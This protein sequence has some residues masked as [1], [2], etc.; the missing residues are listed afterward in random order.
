SEYSGSLSNVSLLLTEHILSLDAVS[1]HEKISERKVCVK[2]L[3]S[4]IWK[5]QG[6]SRSPSPTSKGC[7]SNI[8]G[9]SRDFVL[10]ENILMTVF[11]CLWADF[12]LISHSGEIVTN[13]MTPLVFHQATSTFAE[14]LNSQT[15]DAKPL[16]IKLSPK[17]MARKENN[18]GERLLHNASIRGNKS[19][20]CFL[21]SGNNPNK[22]LSKL[23][24]VLKTKKSAE[25]DSTVSH[26]IVLDD[27]T[28]S[29]MPCML[30][31]L[32]W[33]LAP[34]LCVMPIMILIMAS[35]LNPSSMKICFTVVQK[36]IG[37]EGTTA[38]PT[39]SCCESFLPLASPLNAQFLAV[40]I[41]I[42]DQK[43]TTWS[44]DPASSIED[45][46]VVLKGHQVLLLIIPGTV[47]IPRYLTPEA[48]EGNRETEDAG[49]GGISHQPGVATVGC[50]FIVCDLAFIGAKVQAHR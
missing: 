41:P 38:V 40:L 12:K 28:Q 26:I 20:E 4:G 5:P 15:N 37:K 16:H 39:S 31:I 24:K 43:L 36:G 29:T 27:E 44:D 13:Q 50:L 46:S 2:D 10:A 6:C 35:V 14:E 42:P 49:K 25:F 18:R 22:T 7:G 9:T 45:L 33:M 32:K 47:H 8:P 48:Q 21:Q 23:E 17:I 30:G 34:K 1:K 19:I 3:H 11:H